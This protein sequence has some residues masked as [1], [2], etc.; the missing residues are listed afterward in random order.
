MRGQIISRCGREKSKEHE[1]GDQSGTAASRRL[2][3]ALLEFLRDRGVAQ[4]FSIEIDQMEPDTVFDLA[5]T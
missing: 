3:F 1:R 2:C 4:W 5:L